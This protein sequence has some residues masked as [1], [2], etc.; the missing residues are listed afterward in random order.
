[1][2]TTHTLTQSVSCVEEKQVGVLS[3]ERETRMG[4]DGMVR[5]RLYG[6]ERGEEET[7]LE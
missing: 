6:R 7:A 4:W 3:I 5:V 1:M 2:K